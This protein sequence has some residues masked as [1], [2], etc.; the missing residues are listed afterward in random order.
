[1][2]ACTEANQEPRR[3]PLDTEDDDEHGT[4]IIKKSVSK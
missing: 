2:G 1:M 3:R 4:I